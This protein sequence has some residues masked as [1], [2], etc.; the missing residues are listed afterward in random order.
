MDASFAGKFLEG[1]DRH[2]FL[3]ELEAVV[4]AVK[5]LEHL[6]EG[7][8]LI[9]CDNQAVVFALEDWHCGSRKGAPLLRELWE[10]CRARQLTIIPRWIGSADNA[11]DPLSRGLQLDSARCART[12]ARVRE[13]WPEEDGLPGE[14]ELGISEPEA[15]SA[16]AENYR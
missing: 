15:E 7:E 2:I 9:L 1:D 16:G 10:C 6:R 5:S 13:E 4:H 14:A 12:L 3:K 11:A 8:V